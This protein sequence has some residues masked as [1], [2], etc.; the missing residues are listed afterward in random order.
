MLNRCHDEFAR[1]DSD[2]P[3]K[4][5]QQDQKDKTARDKWHK[6]IQLEREVDVNKSIESEKLK[7][8]LDKRKGEGYENREFEKSRKM[9]YLD[10]LMNFKEE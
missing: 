9:T 3:I 1:Y 5:I 10:A 4:Q 2:N 6:T 8:E 7:H